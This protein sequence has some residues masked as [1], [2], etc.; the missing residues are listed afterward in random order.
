MEQLQLSI[1]KIQEK[2]LPS[3]APQFFSDTSCLLLGLAS[4]PQKVVINYLQ[5]PLCVYD[6]HLHVCHGII[7]T[8]KDQVQPSALPHHAH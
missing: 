3:L 2:L 8:G 6:V 5:F 4:N 1:Q 7:H